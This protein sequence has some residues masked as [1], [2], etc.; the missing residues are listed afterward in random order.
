MRTTVRR[1]KINKYTAEGSSRDER[2]PVG[3]V[4]DALEAEAVDGDV[5][6]VGGGEIRREGAVASEAGMAAVPAVAAAVAAAAV[7]ATL[8]AAAVAATVSAAAVASTPDASAEHGA[9]ANALQA[10]APGF[11]PARGAWPTSGRKPLTVPLPWTAA[12]LEAAGVRV[13]DAAVPPDGSP[14][15][16]EACSSTTPRS[17]AF[18]SATRAAITSLHGA[19]RFLGSQSPCAIISRSF[20]PGGRR[21]SWH[22]RHSPKGALTSLSGA[23]NGGEAIRWTRAPRAG[24][25]AA[26]VVKE[27]SIQAQSVASWAAS[28]SPIAP[29]S[30]MSALR[31][32]PASRS[33]VA[34]VS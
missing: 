7:A 18:R 15:A 10:L 22:A 13:A 16:T 26:A 9:P 2:Q 27:P 11:A 24:P 4:V 17:A 33:T 3:G 20:L 19:Q 29:T 23:V 34:T 25:S 21:G 5:A 14:A 28:M 1:P 32:I 12:V 8:S 31:V 30:G 6:L